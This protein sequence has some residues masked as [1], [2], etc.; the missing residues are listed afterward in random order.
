VAAE[1]L[2]LRVDLFDHPVADSV[3]KVRELQIRRTLDYGHFGAVVAAVAQG[4]AVDRGAVA[5]QMGR[6]A[7]TVEAFLEQVQDLA[8]C[9][10][11][12]PEWEPVIVLVIDAVTRHFDWLIRAAR[13]EPGVEQAFVDVRLRLE[14]AWA[15]ASNK[16]FLERDPAPVRQ[17]SVEAPL[18]LLGD[19][20]SR[21]TTLW[22]ELLRDLTATV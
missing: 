7:D 17:V 13:N 12:H 9:I 10:E 5:H 2:S 22:R 19:A 1:E 6:V 21:F 15:A 16:Q 20:V 18:E 11:E 14:E 8:L 4:W 3:S